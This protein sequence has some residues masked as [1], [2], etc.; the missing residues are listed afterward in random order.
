LTKPPMQY[1]ALVDIMSDI[2][3]M[4]LLIVCLAMLVAVLAQCPSERD[5]LI[6]IFD[7]TNG[8]DWTVANN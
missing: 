5:A 7:A 3:D 4:K 1:L 6:A 2:P 8:L